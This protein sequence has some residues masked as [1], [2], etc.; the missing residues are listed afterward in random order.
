MLNFDWLKLHKKEVRI[1]VLI[2]LLLIICLAGSSISRQRLFIKDGNS[3]VAIERNSLDQNLSIPLE[4]EA[5]K[6]GKKVICQVVL[7]FKGI[8]EMDGGHE[9][10]T[11][12]T[13]AQTRTLEDAILELADGL[14]DSREQTISLP[15]QLEDGTALR[16]KKQRDLRILLVFLL[17]PACLL[18]IYENERQKEKEQRKRYEEEIRR[19]LPSFLDQVLLLLNCGMI[20]HDAFY[21]IQENY[22][23]RKHQDG[24]CQLLQRIGKEAKENGLM[25]VTVMETL[26]GEIGVREYVRMVNI[27]LDHQHRGVNLEDKLQAERRLLWEGR[28][29]NA[30]QK[31][32]EMETKMTFPLAILLLVLI[33]IAGAPALMNL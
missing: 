29:A 28:K 20:F 27:L 15:K 1:L 4:V 18:Y 24:F 2:S 13:S 12:G 6:D 21:R 32:K 3:I 16:W 26:C 8:K 33:T 22:R 30:M 11:A 25:V 9:K 5:Q 31:G 23:K 14:G 7:T 19:A 17:M 10:G